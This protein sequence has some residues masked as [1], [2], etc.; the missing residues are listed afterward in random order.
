MKVSVWWLL[1]GATVPNEYTLDNF[2]V[3]EIVTFCQG[4]VGLIQKRLRYIRD[5]CM[6]EMFVKML[7]IT[8]EHFEHVCLKVVGSPCVLHEG[9]VHFSTWRFKMYIMFVVSIIPD[10]VF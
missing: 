7:Q 9:Q 1:K 10:C 4:I 6:F 3:L 8:F 2:F 5:L